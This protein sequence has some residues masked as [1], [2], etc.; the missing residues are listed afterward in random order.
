MGVFF[1]LLLFLPG[2]PQAAAES[3]ISTIYVTWGEMMELPC[4]LPPVLYGDEL[5]SWFFSSPAGSLT[6][7]VAQVHV[8]WSVPNLGKTKRESRLKLLGNYSLWLEEA[9][10]R[11]AGRYWCTV[12]GRH[13]ERQNWRVYDVSVLK[14]SQFSARAT[15][16]A[17][18]FVLL[19]SVVP[20][21]QLDSVTWLEGKDPVRGHVQSFSSNGAALLLACAGEGQ[22]E[23]RAR[24]LRV[25]RCV[26]PQSKGVSFS[27]AAPVST[28][29]ARCEP[30]SG[31][32]VSW[33]LML[34]LTVGQGFAILALGSMLWKQRVQRVQGQGA[35]FPQFK[36]EVRVYENIHLAPTPASHSSDSSQDPGRK[37]DTN[38][39]EGK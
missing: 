17:P 18:C 39:A 19:C 6:T 8:A 10:D 5:L 37:E 21:R 34:L 32:N 13:L 14:G 26:M 11:D 36:P 35:I 20:A 23:P 28:P 4:P 29:P 1:L 7:R 31:W 38:D 12:M 33:I 24:R 22:P 15:D 3:I 16:G 9:K 30:S 25:I 2:P 27:L